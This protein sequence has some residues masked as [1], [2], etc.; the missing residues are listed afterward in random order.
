MN[1]LLPFEKEKCRDPRRFPMQLRMKLDLCGIKLGKRDWS[2]FNPA[3]KKRLLAMPCDT[4]DHVETFRKTLHDFI[5]ASGGE[6]LEIDAKFAIPRERL[7]WSA[8]APIPE[9]LRRQIRALLNA[10]PDQACWSALSDLQR[11]ALIKLTEP[12]KV[13]PEL[14]QALNEFPLWPLKQGAT[15]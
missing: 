12:G 13:K 9:S 15:R 10:D 6:W 14:I 11:F 1:E 2:S 8:T 3:E 5:Q 7:P 4:P